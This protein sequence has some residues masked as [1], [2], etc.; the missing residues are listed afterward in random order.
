MT[1]FLKSNLF[2]QNMIIVN[3]FFQVDVKVEK[4]EEQNF[5]DT[6]LNIHDE[7]VS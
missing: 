7:Q 5:V 2:S 1:K 6:N 4:H 3:Y